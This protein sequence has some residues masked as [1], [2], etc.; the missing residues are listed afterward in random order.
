M[1]QAAAGHT[2]SR[3]G[4]P[5]KMQFPVVIERAL[6]FVLERYESRQPDLFVSDPR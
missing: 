2:V 6:E 4:V 3:A 5:A 1:Q